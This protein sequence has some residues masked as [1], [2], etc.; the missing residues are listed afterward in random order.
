MAQLTASP[1]AQLTAEKTAAGKAATMWAALEK[2]AFQQ[3]AAELAA[4]GC[5]GK[6]PKAANE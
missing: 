2:S 3:A 4:A 5:A 6:K 1:M